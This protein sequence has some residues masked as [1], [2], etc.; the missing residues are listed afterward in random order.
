MLNLFSEN[1]CKK[2]A[3]FSFAFGLW[4]IIIKEDLFSP[5][6]MELQLDRRF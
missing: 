6:V 3:F 4:K 2:E 1:L 5:L